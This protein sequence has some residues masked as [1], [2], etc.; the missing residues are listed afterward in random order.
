MATNDAANP[1]HEQLARKLCAACISQQMSLKSIDYALKT[2]VN[3]Q[4]KIGDAWIE[5]AKRA[6]EIM[7][8]IKL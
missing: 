4:E 6:A 8:D 7:S 2:Y 5:L 3:K 1:F